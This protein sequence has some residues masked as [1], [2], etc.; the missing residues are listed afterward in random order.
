MRILLIEDESAMAREISSALDDLG[1]DVEIAENLAAAYEAVRSEAPALIIADRMLHG[2][3]SLSFIQEIRDEGIRTPVLIVSGLASVDERIR[4]LKAGSDDY[5]TKPFAIG[6]LAARVEVLLR[7]SIEPRLT[8]LRVGPLEL[9][10]IERRA[11]RGDRVLSLLPREFKL[12][13]YLMRRPNQVVTRDMLFQGVWNYNFMPQTT[14]LVD[15]HIGK[16][17]RKVDAPNEEP[18]IRSVRGAGFMLY[19][20][21]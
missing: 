14:N 1:Y 11:K 8:M 5:I 15:V 9:D 17:R 2:T 6:E 13:E 18:L 3:D 19:A 7:R 21:D 16:V 4:G 10:L 12:L 20:P